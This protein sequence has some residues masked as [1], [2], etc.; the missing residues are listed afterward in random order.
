MLTRE[1]LFTIVALTIVIVITLAVFSWM[2]INNGFFGPELPPG[3]KK[4]LKMN[5]SEIIG[6]NIDRINLQYYNSLLNGG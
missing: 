2:L 5:K 4:V 1:D 3:A 6:K